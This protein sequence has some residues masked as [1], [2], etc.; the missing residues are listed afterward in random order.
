MGSKLGR[1]LDSVLNDIPQDVRNALAKTG[2]QSTRSHP[3][4]AGCQCPML[5]I[6]AH[7]YELG[8]KVVKTDG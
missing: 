2:W 6:M 8:Y 7:L 5:E 4:G 3:Q 1:D